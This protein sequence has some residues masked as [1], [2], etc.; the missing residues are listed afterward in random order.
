VA[1]VAAKKKRTIELEIKAFRETGERKKFID[2]CNAARKVAYG[3]LSKIAHESDSLPASFADSFFLHEVTEV[4]EVTVESM[5]EEIE[6]LAAE[7]EEKRARLT[8]LKSQEEA[9]AKAEAEALAQRAA[10]AEL[11]KIKKDVEKKAAAIRAKL[12]K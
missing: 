12:R 6:A 7:L 11:E 10:L 2:A 3:E 4:E 9:K 5:E 8:Q 1:E